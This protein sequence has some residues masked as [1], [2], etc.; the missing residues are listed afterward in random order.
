MC[1]GAIGLDEKRRRGWRFKISIVL[2]LIIA[3]A[4]SLYL[5]VPPLLT[6]ELL[7]VFS[8]YGWSSNS[9]G[10]IR[11]ATFRLINNGTRTLTMRNVWVNGTLLN[12]TEWGLDR[13]WD[14]P[15]Q[16]DQLAF[17]APKS[18]IFALDTNYEFTFGTA[19]GR[20]FSFIY[21]CDEASVKPENL[22]L[23]DAHFYHESYPFMDWIGIRY[24]NHGTTP[25]IITLVR[26]Y[27]SL[28]FEMREWAS[29]TNIGSIIIDYKWINQTYV[30]TIETV[31]GNTYEMVSRPAW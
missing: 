20:R 9:N 27:Y 31:V 1:L 17:V 10:Q 6:F 25:A 24:Y 11:Q 18:M 3:I 4:L 21:R 16:I 7:E 5:V 14:F 26:I 13:D 12:S 8:F 29:P 2:I 30:F 28:T 22:T 15:P 23:I 19:S